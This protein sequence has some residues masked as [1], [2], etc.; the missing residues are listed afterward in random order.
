MFERKEFLV[1]HEKSKYGFQM[2]SAATYECFRLFAYNIQWIRTQVKMYFWGKNGSVRP[3][4]NGKDNE[5]ICCIFI[6]VFFFLGLRKIFVNYENF[7]A[8]L[9]HWCSK[10]RE[11]PVLLFS[12]FVHNSSFNEHKNMKL[13]ENVF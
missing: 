12:S 3:R 13:R 4:D 6:W 2:Y 7:W 10:F 1:Q 11:Q 5:S 9:I 8:Q